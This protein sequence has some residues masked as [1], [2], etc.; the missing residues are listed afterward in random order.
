MAAAV[1]CSPKSLE[2]TGAFNLDE[3]FAKDIWRKV[4]LEALG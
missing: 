2:M 4:K 3:D 1:G